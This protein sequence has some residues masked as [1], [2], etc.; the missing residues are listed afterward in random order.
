MTGTIIDTPLDLRVGRHWWLL[1]L[2][3]VLAII[4]GILAFTWPGE[5]LLVLIAFFGAYMFID[6]IVALVA[7]I[8]FR[9]EREQWPSLLLEGVIGIIIGVVTFFLPG[10]TA[11]AWAFLVAAWALVTGVLEIIT[12]FRL[13]T[14]IRDEILFIIA[15]IL[16]ILFGIV[17]AALPRQGLLALIWVIAAYAIVF[18]ILLIALSFRVRGITKPS[19]PAAPIG[20]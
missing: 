20:G 4:F 8:R 9:H 18:G 6:G 15:G 13:R 3:G 7:A 2:R 19:A 11:L 16:S 5:T 14:I 1:A 10:I 12:A 17:M